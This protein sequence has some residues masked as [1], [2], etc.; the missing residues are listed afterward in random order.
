M[1]PAATAANLSRN[2]R[3]MFWLTIAF[4][5]TA[6]LVGFWASLHYGGKVDNGPPGK[7]GASGTIVVTAV[8]MFFLSMFLAA[9]R[10][11]FGP[12]LRPGHSHAAGEACSDDGAFGQCQH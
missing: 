10:A 1:V 4:S 6:G 8:A 3:Q 9:A 7:F 5:L 11:R 12:V 2:L